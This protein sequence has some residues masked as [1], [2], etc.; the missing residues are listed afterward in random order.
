MNRNLFVMEMKRNALSFL[1]WALAITL[2][3]S[4]TMLAYPTFYENQSKIMGFITLVPKAALQFKGVQ[5]FADIFSVLGFYAA[6]NVIYMMVLGSIFAI[7]LSSGIL[8]K[9]EYNRSAEYLLTRPITR[10]E[11]FVSKVSIVLLQ[12]IALNVI[13]SLAGFIGM[14]VVKKSPY[15]I[16][17]FL[18]LSLYTLLL[19]L[20]FGAAGLFLST[21]V[22]KPRPISTFCIA[23]VLVLYFIFTLSKI[24]T[25]VE[26]I[27]YLSPFRYVDMNAAASGYRLNP[28]YLLYFVGISLLLGGLAYR[29]YLR[30]DVYT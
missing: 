11:V 27:G 26:K 7:G 23:L 18:A 4:V 30:K 1:I 17:A 20:L 6:N 16:H 5:N 15:S 13:T 3:V 24:A 9:E 29:F 14:E 28:W 10:S 2:L 25:S 22:R 19:N 12:V 21:V 8:L